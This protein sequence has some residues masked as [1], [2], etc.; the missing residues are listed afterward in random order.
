MDTK[1]LIVGAGPVGLTLAIALARQGVPLR[2][3]EKA[4]ARTPYSKALVVWSRTLEMLEIEG[5]A[6]QFVQTG[7]QAH[8]VSIWAEHKRLVNLHFTEAQI[9]TDYPFAL[10]LAQSETERLL[11]NHLHALGVTVER[12][13]EL[14]EHSAHAD[15]VTVKLRHAD[16]QIETAQAAWLAACDGA[17]STV[18][19]QIS[20]A[21]FEGD[22]L[23]TNWLLGDIKLESSL[24][25]DE[26]AM[27]WADDG[28]LMAIPFGEGRFRVMGNVGEGD[29]SH[30]PSPTLADLQHLLDRR[31][32]VKAVAQDPAWISRFVINERKVADYRHGRVFLVGDAAHIHS[33]AGG[34][35]MNTG[36]QDAFNLAWKLALVCRG[37]AA[38][39]LLD[40]Y[41][42][43]RSAIGAQVL[44]DAGNLTRVALISNPLL[45]QL[46]A[47]AVGTLTHLDAVRRK[48]AAQFSELELHYND[49]P[50]SLAPPGHATHL[51]AG[52]RVPNAQ[53]AGAGTLY[54]VLNGGR[55][56]VAALGVMPRLSTATQRL[57]VAVELAAN[58]AFEAGH[59]YVIRPD[60]YL[61]FSLSS[62]D[63]AALDSLLERVIRGGI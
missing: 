51:A 31:S 5:I 47:L 23:P 36:M 29:Q 55:F 19:H 53:L 40:T 1:V 16:G 8:G 32:A 38:E 43:E 56:V 20:A 39:S 27:F 25:H 22:T 44:K 10:M 14:L 60:G 12:E 33:P 35:G 52:A 3:V 49:S 9:A 26:I 13:V 61:A 54:S 24:P 17:H 41:S 48:I 6:A 15:S 18:R 4:A 45:Q 59:W 28:L 21:R 58:S 11:E 34:Q 62:D 63:P 30:L 7:M 50:L 46:R 37:D 42:A 2:I 57:A